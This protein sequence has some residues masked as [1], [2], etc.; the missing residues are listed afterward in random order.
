M[1]GAKKVIFKACHSGKLYLV[2]TSLKVI[3]TSPKRK[4]FFV[5]GIDYSSSVIWTSLASRASK[6]R[7]L[8][9]RKIQ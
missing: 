7:I 9:P 3:S 6:N 4:G 8:Q 5:N 1:Q 2:R